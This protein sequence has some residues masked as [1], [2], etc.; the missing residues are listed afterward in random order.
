MASKKELQKFQKS[1][2]YI[3][4]IK[5]TKN[6]RIDLQEKI[7]NLYKD[8]GDTYTLKYNIHNHYYELSNALR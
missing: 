4:L 7:L 6:R 2:E 3:D 5:K 1:E 8:G